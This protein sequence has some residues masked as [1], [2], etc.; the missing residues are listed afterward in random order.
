VPS[1]SEVLAMAA[2][3]DPAGVR[4]L[5]GYQATTVACARRPSA[6]T[7]VSRSCLRERGRGGDA[8]GDRAMECTGRSWGGRGACSGR[9]RTPPG[10]S[11]SWRERK[12]HA[13]PPMDGQP[14]LHAGLRHL[15]SRPRRCS[16][17]APLGASPSTA[18]LPRAHPPSPSI[19]PW[20][21]DHGR[22]GGVHLEGSGVSR[23]YCRTQ[24]LQRARRDA[25]QPERADGESASH[26]STR[27][28]RFVRRIW[29]QGRQ[30][31]ARWYP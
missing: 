9:H 7:R 22:L 18:P 26:Q 15:Q 5:G 6:V 23:T 17:P 11:G 3:R 13:G 16:A 2:A 30:C 21:S 27:I 20:P 28:T 24:Q 19:R 25:S 4:D 1:V 31:M 29:A 10:L 12:R 14:V 8:L